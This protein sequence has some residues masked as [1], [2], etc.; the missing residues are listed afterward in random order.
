M[1]FSGLCYLTPMLGGYIPINSGNRIC[2]LRRD[3]N[4]YRAIMLLECSQ[5][6]D[7]AGITFRTTIMWVALLAVI[8]GNGFSSLTFLQWLAACTPR[9]KKANL[10]RHLQFFI[11]V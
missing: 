1:G 4:G 11:W 3:Y 8:L 6:H 2:I 9:A 5:S 7:A 10:I